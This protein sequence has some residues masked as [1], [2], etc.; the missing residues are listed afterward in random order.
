MA[1]TEPAPQADCLS[2][3]FRLQER[4]G[5]PPDVWVVG[6]DLAEIGVVAGYSGTGGQRQQV[7]FRL[8]I[9]AL[10]CAH[11]REREY[12]VTYE[13]EAN[14]Q[15]AARMKGRRRQ[16]RIALASSS[17]PE[18]A[19][20]DAHQQVDDFPYNAPTRVD[21][22]LAALPADSRCQRITVVVDVTQLF[23]SI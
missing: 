1:G 2:P 8:R 20:D 9:G 11:N 13:I 5:A 4:F 16:G 18:E 23:F 22:A 10:Q 19:A 3:I 21:N 17:Q 14:Y 15:N 12:Q 6:N 7:D